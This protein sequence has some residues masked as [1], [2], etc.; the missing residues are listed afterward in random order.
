MWL[1]RG[2]GG[3][4]WWEVTT[5]TPENRGEWGN[6]GERSD[7]KDRIVTWRCRRGRDRPHQR[8]A[9]SQVY[10]RA[11]SDSSQPECSPICVHRHRPAPNVTHTSRARGRCKTGGQLARRSASSQ[12]HSIPRGDGEPHQWNSVTRAA[13]IRHVGHDVDA[14]WRRVHPPSMMEARE[15][16]MPTVRITTPELDEI[17]ETSQPKHTSPCAQLKH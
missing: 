9:W 3:E 12:H 17:R 6:G 8:E 11:L 4:P 13:Y 2:G 1:N 16:R 14:Q 7:W 5:R 15:G 10:R